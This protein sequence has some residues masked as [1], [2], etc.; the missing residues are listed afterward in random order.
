MHGVGFQC[1]LTANGLNLESVA[2]NLDR[3]AALGLDLYVT[4]MDVRLTLPATPDALAKQ[5][6]LYWGVLDTFLMQP[7][8]RGFQSWGFTDRHS[9]I[10]SAYPGQGAGLPLDEQYQPKPAYYALRDR[11]AA[12]V[13]PAVLAATSEV[14]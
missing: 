3:F 11:L 4:E 1:H 12:L 10:P 9:W 7:A 8:F 6:S 14:A 2:R 5:G 13:E